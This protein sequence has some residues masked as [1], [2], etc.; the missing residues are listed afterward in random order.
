MTQKL[1][2]QTVWLTIDW[3]ESAGAIPDAQQEALTETLFRD[4]HGVD[5]VEAI[6]R[7]ADPDAPVGG[8]GAAWLWSILTTEITLDGLKTLGRE[9]QA[10]LPGR[11]IEFTVKAGDR[12]VTVK[13]LRPADLEAT[14]DKLVDAAKQL[15]ED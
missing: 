4:L 9:A 10:R 15:A 12:A 8:M 2:T 5:G 7:V 1:V 13:N 14:L 3:R 11:P 6:R